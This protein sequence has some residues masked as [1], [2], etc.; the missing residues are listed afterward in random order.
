[1]YRPPVT[2]PV[3]DGPGRPVAFGA[4]VQHTWWSPDFFRTPLTA[5]LHRSGGAL[6]RALLPTAQQIRKIAMEA[7]TDI[8]TT[9]LVRSMCSG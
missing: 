3:A 7:E 1:V 2:P 9:Q 5:A 4:K 8:S 6:V